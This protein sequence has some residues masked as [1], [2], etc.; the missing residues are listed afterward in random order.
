MLRLL[1]AAAL[2]GGAF[3]ATPRRGGEAS[4]GGHL[5]VAG[6]SR[7]SV[8]VSTFFWNVHWECSVGQAAGSHPDCKEKV[9][10]RFV[11]LA[12]QTGADI[13]FSVMLA[14][15]QNVP[16]KLKSFGLAEG[17]TQVD[18]TCYYEGDDKQFDWDVTA[19]A[20]GPAWTVIKSG[21]GCLLPYW[22]T[23]AF[24]VAL[25]EP[26]SII[27]GCPQ[28]C[29]LG[30]HAPQ[31]KITQGSELVKNVCGNLADTCSIAMGDW[32]Q[33]AKYVGSHWQ[34]LIGGAVPAVEEIVPDVT[35][36][37]WS[38]GVFHGMVHDKRG[39]F[40]HIATSIAGA[41]HVGQIVHDYQHTDMMPALQH[42]PVT[43]HMQ[44]P[45]AGRLG[46]GGCTVF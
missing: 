4:L 16:S 39:E 40:D 6:S 44:L 23:Y 45:M 46:D 20:F 14:D 8:K 2:A 36:C 37:C 12:S 30:V 3:A 38:A 22:D 27:Q 31:K 35:T 32:N 11:E 24:A 33:E 19:L 29:V 42:K 21:G 10:K 17:W 25:V 34:Q 43:A 18:G 13:V 26:P 5:G 9:G 1:S 28:L 15:A 7:G 41:R